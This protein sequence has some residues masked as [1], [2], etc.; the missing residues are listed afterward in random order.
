MQGAGAD[1]GNG[2]FVGAKGRENKGK[3]AAEGATCLFTRLDR[4]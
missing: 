2:A 1:K 3:G 4:V